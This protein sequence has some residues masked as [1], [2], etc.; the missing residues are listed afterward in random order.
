MENPNLKWMIWGD[1]HGPQIVFSQK[2]VDFTWLCLDLLTEPPTFDV[3]TSDYF[4]LGGR[5]RTSN[6]QN[7]SSIAGGC[8]TW[9]QGWVEQNI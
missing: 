6:Q 8:V 5:R 1:P 9:G 4:P 3:P 7:S 2:H